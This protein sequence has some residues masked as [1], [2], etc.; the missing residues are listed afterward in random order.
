MLSIE[1]L[2]SG[3]GRTKVLHEISLEVPDEGLVAILGHN[4]AGKST[5]MKT[6]IGLIR[7]LHGTIMWD[8]EDISKVSPHE[9][10]RRG[11]AYVPQGQQS[12]GQLTALENM[13]LVAGS[14]HAPKSLID[15]MMDR[16]PDLRE[17]GSRKAELMSGGQRQQLAIARALITQPKLLILDEPGEGIQ[18]SIVADIRRTILELA[19]SG[20][21]VLLVEQ[22]IDFAVMHCS[23]YFVMA[24]GRIL[25]GGNGGQ[26]S[27]S[28]VR[29]VLTI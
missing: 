8:G 7:T 6:I 17:Y 28:A 1:G 11:I 12:F 14:S 16:F 9:R 2:V 21:Q 18:P 26:E 20:I 19:A 22:Q 27:V 15:D 24:S 13:E 3:Y 29:E 23:R 25:S 4:G 10:V 5:L